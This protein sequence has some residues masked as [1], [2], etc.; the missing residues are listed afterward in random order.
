MDY[1]YKVV[2]EVKRRVPLTIKNYEKFNHDIEILKLHI[3]NLPTE[4]PTCD[5]LKLWRELGEILHKY[6][7][8]YIKE[9][10]CTNMFRYAMDK[11]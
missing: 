5:I 9:E 6:C 11:N 4:T 3:V 7:A 8:P 2:S 10:W 1:L